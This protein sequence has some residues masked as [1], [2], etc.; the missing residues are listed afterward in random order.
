MKQSDET[1]VS[2]RLKQSA[3]AVFLP[4]LGKRNLLAH[5]DD[6]ERIGLHFAA[7]LPGSGRIKIRGGHEDV[8]RLQI[9]AHGARAALGWDVLHHTVF[10]RRVFMDNGENAFAARSKEGICCRVEG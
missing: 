5:N 10:I 4:R 9:Q 2:E 1:P 8:M 7:A 3:V 6:D